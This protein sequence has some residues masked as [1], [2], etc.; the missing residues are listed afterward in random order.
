MYPLLVAFA[1]KVNFALAKNENVTAHKNATTLLTAWSF[2]M[3]YTMMPN[4]AQ[5]NAVFTIPTEM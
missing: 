3:M 2:F 4:T 1:L 5:C